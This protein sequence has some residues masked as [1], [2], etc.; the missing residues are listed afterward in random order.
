MRSLLLLAIVALPLA[1]CEGNVKDGETGTSVSIDAEGNS[2]ETVKVTADG[3]SGEVAVN[4]PGFAGKLDLPKFVLNNS[5]FD[6]DGVKLYPGSTITRMNVNAKDG[7]DA[8]VDIAFTAPAE[9]AK[10][11]DYLQKAFAEKK[12][13]VTTSGTALSGTTTDGN[14]FS[15]ALEPGAGGTA[16]R[17]NIDAK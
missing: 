16:G 12:M 2:G 5:N 7:G 13:A 10:V 8:K 14:A 1:A 11:A 6:I 3:N 9:P 4:V 15:I 17:I